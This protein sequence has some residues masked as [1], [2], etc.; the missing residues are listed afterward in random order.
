MK[1]SAAR[2]NKHNRPFVNDDKVTIVAKQDKSKIVGFDVKFG[3]K[4]KFFPVKKHNIT[5]AWKE[6]EN[7]TKTII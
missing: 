1:V 2:P 3:M 4:Q 6:V 7:F 5:A